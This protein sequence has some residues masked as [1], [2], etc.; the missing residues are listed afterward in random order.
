MKR[1]VFGLVIVM[2]IAAAG[3]AQS[4]EGGG[5]STKRIEQLFS[6]GQSFEDNQEYDE[7]ISVYSEIIGLDPDNTEAYKNRGNAYAD[8]GDIA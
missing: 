8:K 3:Y 6:A 7:A 2:T 1:A 4:G 5:A